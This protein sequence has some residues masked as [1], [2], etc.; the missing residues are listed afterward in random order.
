MDIKDKI[1]ADLIENY[2]E[3][4]LVNLSPKTKGDIN[5]KLTNV[6]YKERYYVEGDKGFVGKRK[7]ISDAVE[8]YLENRLKK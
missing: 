6:I 2:Y 5:K 3:E 4:I 8:K 7:Q 1:I